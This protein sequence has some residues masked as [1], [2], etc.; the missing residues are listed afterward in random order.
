M[1]CAQSWTHVQYVTNSGLFEI[2]P[3]YTTKVHSTI[4]FNTLHCRSKYNLNALSHDTA[5]G[6][7]QR[8]LDQGVN[9]T[10]V[11]MYCHVPMGWVSSKLPPEGPQPP[12]TLVCKWTSIST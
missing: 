9:V 4:A 3:L 7:I 2:C 1:E 5:I 6:M 12:K 11:S 10:E 8:A